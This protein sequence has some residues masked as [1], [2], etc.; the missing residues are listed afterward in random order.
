MSYAH[1]HRLLVLFHKTVVPTTCLISSGSQPRIRWSINALGL[2]RLNW[3]F[4]YEN[5]EACKT[6][7]VQKSF[8]LKN[9]IFDM[10]CTRL[11]PLDRRE[12][13]IFPLEDSMLPLRPGRVKDARF[14]DGAKHM[15]NSAGEGM[16]Y[17]WIDGL[18][19]L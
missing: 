4:G 12:D 6:G 17:A 2:N 8:S 10:P 9:G 13:E 3:E 18:L 5:V 19:V 14:V 11:V 15:R 7:D 1:H 16:Q